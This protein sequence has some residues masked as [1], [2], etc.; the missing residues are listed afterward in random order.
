MKN[1]P[2]V[3]IKGV[4]YALLIVFVMLVLYFAVPSAHSMKR[5]IFPVVFILAGIFLILGVV[6][7][8]LTLKM[9]VKGKLKVFLLLTGSAAAGFLV[10]V[11]L[12]N[13]VYGL[14]VYFFGEN[15][16]AGL[17]GDEPFFFI[18]AIIVCP[19]AFFV[20]II[21]SLVLFLKKKR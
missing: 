7:I 12:H 4:F 5:A 11:L 1:E 16:W 6:L 18:L 19:I 8:I 15:F 9:K 13:L 14:F 3:K 2:L 20:G 10:F 21:G 17:G